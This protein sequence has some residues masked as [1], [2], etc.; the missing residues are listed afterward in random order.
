MSKI[1]QILKTYLRIYEER[2][3]TSLFDTAQIM[4][5]ICFSANVCQCDISYSGVYEHLCFKTLI[6]CITELL[7][8]RP[9]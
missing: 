1:F 8:C 9:G 4:Y 6:L 2:R 7:S 3:R 5:I